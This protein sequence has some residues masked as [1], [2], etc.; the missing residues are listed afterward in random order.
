[1]MEAMTTTME[2]AT[3]DEEGDTN[4]FLDI[5]KAYVR[6]AEAIL[7]TTRADYEKALEERNIGEIRKIEG[8]LLTKKFE[9]LT[10]GKVDF[11]DYINTMRRK[12]GV[13]EREW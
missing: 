1:M 13:E 4:N 3:M 11:G 6:L 5:A 10:F 12:Y 8:D 2:V 7:A 9:I